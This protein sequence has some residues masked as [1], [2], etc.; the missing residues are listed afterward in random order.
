[1]RASHLVKTDRYLHGLR[2]D[3]LK[4]FAEST[5]GDIEAYRKEYSVLR[6]I[7]YTQL[8]YTLF[9]KMKIIFD[10]SLIDDGNRR[11][12]KVSFAVQNGTTV[13]EPKPKN[14]E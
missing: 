4:F 7:K 14:N 12:G 10:I 2:A 13:Y 9:L 5:R 3:G 6:P 1:M 11:I 8:I